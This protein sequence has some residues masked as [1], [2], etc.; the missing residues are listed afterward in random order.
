M[1]IGID[2][3]RANKS[4]KTGTEWYSFHLI[5]EL[6]KIDSPNRFVLYSREEL[7][8]ELGQLPTNFESKVLKWPPKFLWTQ[9]RLSWEMLVRP[10]DVLFVPAHT[11]PILGRVKRVVTIHDVG[12]RVYPELYSWVDI[13]YHRFSVWFA[14]RFAYKI[15]CVSEFTKGELIKY[16]HTDPKKVTVIPLGVKDPNFL[17]QAKTSPFPL[18]MRRGLEGV[19]GLNNQNPFLLFIGRL[20]KKKNILG[21]LK[22]FNALREKFP[23]LRLV[24]AGL[25]GHGFAEIE[26]YLRDQKLWDFVEIRGYIT[27]IEKQELY[28]GACAFV[29]PTFYEG[30][31]MPILEAQSLGCP[32][33]TSKY[34]ATAEVAKNSA[35]LV[36]P[37][38]PVEIA[39]AC[40]KLIEDESL[41]ESLIAA[42]L[43][44]VKQYT[45]A[46]TAQKT[47]P[48][49]L[50]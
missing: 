35:L 38:E 30:F 32:V 26:N 17:K 13:L 29:F 43:E 20:E 27:E 16:Y 1:T 47:Y 14:S 4:Q 6:K 19:P 22:A 36:D 39:G 23:T 12:F 46:S 49:L 25:P 10:P 8:G 5:E 41:R 40:S 48:L 33:V 50:N 3:S 2:A 9:V 31:G 11:V 37:Q 18:L 21:I 15:I 42:G 28:R 24:L 34:G 7:R 44:N 45:W